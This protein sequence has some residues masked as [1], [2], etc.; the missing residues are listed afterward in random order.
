LAKTSSSRQLVDNI[1]R[2]NSKNRNVIKEQYSY[3]AVI[4]YVSN[5]FGAAI[6]PYARWYDPG[7][8]RSVPIDGRE[9]QRIIYLAW[10]D[11]NE[12][13]SAVKR[14]KDFLIDNSANIYANSCNNEGVNRPSIQN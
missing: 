9:F 10:M 12:L 6:L 7:I 3:H 13:S 1:F 11:D 2:S 8:V 4:S 14:V 5:N